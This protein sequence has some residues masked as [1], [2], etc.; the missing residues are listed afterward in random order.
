MANNITRLSGAIQVDD[1]L[2]VY[3]TGQINS[4]GITVDS[5]D[6]KNRFAGHT[7]IFVIKL[8][9][10]AN[11]IWG[12]SIGSN[13]VE[14]VGDMK[15]ISNDELILTGHFASDTLLIGSHT[16]LYESKGGFNYFIAKKGGKKTVATK[17]I[18]QH[19]SLELIP[20]PA[21]TMVKFVLPQGIHVQGK[22][23]LML[24]GMDGK[25]IHSGHECVD[26][27][28]IIDLSGVPSRCYILTFVF[29]RERYVQKLIVQ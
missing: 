2:N 15:I 3:I 20:N 1:Y 28:M 5:L 29:A 12:T 16:L 10:Q 17:N 4:P 14:N 7:D 8:D 21:N 19:N 11:L 6:I 24:T 26:K 23:E 22:Y 18:E 13:S 9:S 25:Q 27:E